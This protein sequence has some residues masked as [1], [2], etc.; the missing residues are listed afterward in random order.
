MFPDLPFDTIIRIKHTGILLFGFI[1]GA[2]AMFLFMAYVLRSV[3]H[4][5][6]DIEKEIQNISCWKIDDCKGHCIFTKT[7][8]SYSGA[9]DNLY[10]AIIMTFSRKMT[11]ALKSIKRAKLIT[12]MTIAILLIITATAALLGHDVI[13]P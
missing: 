1:S 11:I 2:L 12:R 13:T 8:D 4:L 3:R 10:L 5:D 7:R 9:I 6:R